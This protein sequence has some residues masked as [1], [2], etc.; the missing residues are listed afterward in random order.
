MVQ[1]AGGELVAGGA[2]AQRAGRVGH[3][4]VSL[5]VG[6]AQVEMQPAAR[7]VR[8]R[9]GHGGKHR[10]V[11]RRHRLRGEL[12]ELVTVGGGERVVVLV[13]DLVLATRVFVVD[14]LQ[15]EAQRGERL[16]HRIEKRVV[17]PDDLQVVRGFG[18]AVQGIGHL[19][20]ALGVAVEQE[21]LGLDADPQRPAARV[22]A[23]DLALEHLARAGVQRLA[24]GKTVAHRVRHAGHEGQG[25]QALGHHTAHV[26]AARAH[27]RQAGA[28]DARAREAGTAAHRTRQAFERHQLALGTARQV[29]EG[30]EHRVDA[31]RAQGVDTFV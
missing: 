25:P 2:Q 16:A 7:R 1:Q 23:L 20:A 19:P 27:A 18:E 26:F 21:E 24:A 6:Q 12:E 14:L 31:L 11:L 5:A 3:H 29:G 13:V 15:P 4:R 10:A 17:A 8:Q 30:G 28:A 9:L 22:Q